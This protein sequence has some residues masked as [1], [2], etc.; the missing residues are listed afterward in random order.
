[1]LSTKVT[2]ENMILPNTITWLLTSLPP[3]LRDNTFISL[4][5]GAVLLLVDC[6]PSF[7]LLQIREIL[8]MRGLG[9]CLS[10]P[11]QR[12]QLSSI[13]KPISK[14]YLSSLSLRII[15]I[16]CRTTRNTITDWNLF[17]KLSARR[18]DMDLGIH[19]KGR[20][21][22]ITVRCL[23]TVSPIMRV[24]SASHLRSLI[25]GSDSSR[26]TGAI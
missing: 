1:M 25:G 16:S 5:P 6:P 4:E 11:L 13:E 7:D 26:S 14:E 8:D 12:I 10:P 22:L 20:Y 2:S 18:K 3:S 19:L 21:F 9:T 23:V 17:P 15:R 24:I